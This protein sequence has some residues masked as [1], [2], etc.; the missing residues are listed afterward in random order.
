MSDIVFLEA[1]K[2]RAKGREAT[3]FALRMAADEEA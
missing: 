1:M 2:G 3:C